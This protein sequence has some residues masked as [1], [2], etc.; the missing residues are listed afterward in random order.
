MDR[1]VDKLIDRWASDVHFHSSLFK[2]RLGL[3]RYSEAVQTVFNILYISKL[4]H[5][6]IVNL[7]HEK[8]HQWVSSK[9]RPAHEILTLSHICKCN[10]V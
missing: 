5:H 3:E 4:Y 7:F 8:N 1:W 2:L 6:T 10:R 9:N